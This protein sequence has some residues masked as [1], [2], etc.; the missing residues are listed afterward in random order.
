MFPIFCGQS[1]V[2]KGNAVK[3][4]HVLPIRSDQTVSFREGYPR[5][6]LESLPFFTPCDDLFE[7]KHSLSHHNEING[8][9]KKILGNHRRMMTTHHCENPWIPSPY[10]L[11]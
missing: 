10:L 7:G 3:I 5:Y 9:R 2:G 6:P 4:D 11:K 8:E 1:P